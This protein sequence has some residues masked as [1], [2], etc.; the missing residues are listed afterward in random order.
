MHYA[1]R[2]NFIRVPSEN[3]ASLCVYGNFIHRVM[4]R[5]GE[6]ISVSINEVINEYMTFE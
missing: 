6:E 1:R 4:D 3:S 2:R 5:N